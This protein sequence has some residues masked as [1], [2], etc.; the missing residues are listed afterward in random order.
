M[1]SGDWSVVSGM[2]RAE[3]LD[4][5]EAYEPALRLENY[6]SGSIS[7][8][9]TARINGEWYSWPAYEVDGNTWFCYFSMG[10]YSG[11]GSYDCTFYVDGAEVCSETLAVD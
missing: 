10:A 7:P 6:S 1:N 11:P 5:D 9:V 4:W 2:P 3:D 8:T